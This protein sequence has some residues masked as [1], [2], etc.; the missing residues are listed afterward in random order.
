ML[1]S[2]SEL[3]VSLPSGDGVDGEAISSSPG[4]E[5][6]SVACHDSAL[7]VDLGQVGWGWAH[8]SLAAPGSDTA[9]RPRRDAEYYQ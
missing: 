6:Q 2:S 9:C 1:T 4:V 8:L 3:V 7:R 5:E